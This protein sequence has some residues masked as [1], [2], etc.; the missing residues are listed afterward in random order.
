MASATHQVVDVWGSVASEPFR[1]SYTWGYAQSLDQTAWRITTGCSRVCWTV[2][3]TA[4]WLQSR[5]SDLG[6]MAKA[7]FA[8]NRGSRLCDCSAPT[9]TKGAATGHLARI[10]R[11]IA[12]IW[13][14]CLCLPEAQQLDLCPDW[15]F[16]QSWLQ[17]LWTHPLESS[18]GPSSCLRRCPGSFGHMAQFLCVGKCPSFGPGA[19]KRPLCIE[20]AFLIEYAHGWRWSQAPSNLHE[21]RYCS[22]ELHAMAGIRHLPSDQM[23]ETANLPDSSRSNVG[24]FAFVINAFPWFA[25]SS[26][27]LK[28]YGFGHDVHETSGAISH[29]SPKRAEVSLPALKWNEIYK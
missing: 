13:F 2:Q 11:W 25:R 22:S 17:I 6:W 21:W 29:C 18:W 20:L 14:I 16:P 7:P 19:A 12:Y 23:L 3:G 1:S 26:F 10:D 5:W 9:D 27:W 28:T 24:W 8:I 4:F 15:S